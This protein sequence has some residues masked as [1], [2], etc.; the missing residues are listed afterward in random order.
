MRAGKVRLAW[1]VR[2][3]K[4]EGEGGVTE[5]SARLGLLTVA[6]A[7]RAVRAPLF[8]GVLLDDRHG[9]ADRQHYEQ[10]GSRHLDR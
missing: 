9:R 4:C 6:V 1:Q 5:V 3:K 2:A 7:S 10:G 8:R